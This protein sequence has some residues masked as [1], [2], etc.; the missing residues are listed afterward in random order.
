MKKQ[1]TGVLL[2]TALAL[3]AA[4]FNLVKGQTI[5]AAASDKE[6][7][8]VRIALDLLKRDTANVLDARLEVSFYIRC[9]QLFFLQ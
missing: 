1:L 7:E 6:A 4:D 5:H 2:M 9:R 3:S 8:T